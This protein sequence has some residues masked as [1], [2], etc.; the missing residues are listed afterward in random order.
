[1]TSDSIWNQAAETWSSTGSNA[2]TVGLEFSVSGPGVLGG[3]WLWSPSGESLTSLPTE[4]ALYTVSGS[5]LVTSNTPS[6]SGAAGSGWVYAAFAGP[7]TL[8][9]STDYMAC[10]FGAAASFGYDS[11]FTWPVTSSP[12]TGVNGGYYSTT[13]GS[14]AYPSSQQAGWNWWVDVSFSPSALTATASLTVTPSLSAAASA[15][16]AA[17]LTVTPV[18]AASGTHGHFRTASLTVTPS[19]SVAT[20]HGHA[21]T[22]ALTVT[23]V[24]AVSPAVGTAASLTVTPSLAALASAAESAALTVL[25]SLAAS[26]APGTAATLAV[27]PEFAATVAGGAPLAALTVT[28]VFTAAA[29]TVLPS[30]G[31]L[32]AAG[33]I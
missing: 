13:S 24:L 23:P 11:S 12:I 26:A 20:A 22:A 4:I 32:M 1:M 6:W 2:G 21:P 10:V 16:A 18:L 15:G 31:L 17:A 25:L 14:L 27:T 8:T 7:P 30:S 3:L 29:E 28:P 19:L 5:T 9:A 33:I